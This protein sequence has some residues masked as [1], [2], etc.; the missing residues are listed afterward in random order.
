MNRRS[1]LLVHLVELID[2]ANPAVS[3]HQCTAFECDV[4]GGV[5][6]V[7][8]GG[9]TR[10]AR[11]LPG[12]VHGARGNVS[13]LLQ[14][15]ALGHSRIAHHQGVD[16]P[17]DFETI[18]HLLGRRA[19]QDQQKCLLQ[20]LV[21]KDLRSNRLRC[22]LIEASTLLRLCDL[23]LQRALI[24]DGLT[25]ATLVLLEMMCFDKHL[26]RA[27][28]PH[29]HCVGEI[30]G[31]ED[32]RQSDGLARLYHAGEIAFRLHSHRPGYS[33]RRH[34]LCQLLNFHLLVAGEGAGTYHAVQVAGLLVLFALCRR[35]L[36]RR[37]IG[38]SLDGLEDF[39]AASLT[40]VCDDLHLGLHLLYADHQAVQLHQLSH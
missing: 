12:G 34:V 40:M 4:T 38:V 25:V 35:A 31:K 16:V 11:A 18:L 9:K 10:R 8:A 32:T 17:T 36:L 24:S 15:L 30:L 26:L 28:L 29:P 7:H 14:Q 33:A 1:V 39:T 3:H 23:V 27:L 13:Y 20:I 21:A 2:A 37:R 22:G 19:D 6:A 5:V